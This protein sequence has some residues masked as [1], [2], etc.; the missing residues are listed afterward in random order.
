MNMLKLL[1]A[2]DWDAI[3][4]KLTVK[5]DGDTYYDSELAWLDK[6]ASGEYRIWFYVCVGAK[7]GKCANIHKLKIGTLANFK[8]SFGK[9]FMDVHMAPKDYNVKEFNDDN[10]EDKIYAGTYNIH[11]LGDVGSDGYTI[12]GALLHELIEK[13]REKLYAGHF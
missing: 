11:W 13:M 2:E 8:K 4:A 6:L 5:S 7:N 12:C 1:T 10:A 9:F 3:K